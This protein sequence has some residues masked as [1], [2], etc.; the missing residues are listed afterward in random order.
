MTATLNAA[1]DA[2]IGLMQTI[3]TKRSDFAEVKA[4]T[5]HGCIYGSIG[6]HPHEAET[7][8]DV[9]E[10]ELTQEA[11]HPKIIGIGETGLDYY[12]EHSPRKE[13]QELFRR[14][15]NVSRKLNLPLIVHTRDAEE[16]TAAI[17]AEETAKGEFP[18]LLHCFS[19]SRAL[20][21]KALELG[22]YISFSGILTFK[23]ADELRECARNFPLERLLVETDAP[24]LAPVPHRGKSNT[25]AYTLH[26]AEM[27]AE[28]RGI[29]LDD[30]ARATTE[31]FFRLFTKV[32][33]NQ[34]AA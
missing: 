2:G 25:P 31:N 4:L 26:T 9:T 3:S 21:E 12:Y 11:N 28:V 15:I 10:A 20:G 24:Y 16:D 17:L 29:A 34:L 13:Q 32:P 14:H 30:V 8:M 5:A 23:K 18:F 33:R 27:L 6:I 7:H 19:S 22:G 1:K